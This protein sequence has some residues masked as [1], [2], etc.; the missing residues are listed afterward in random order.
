MNILDAIL[1]GLEK[2]EEGEHWAKRNNSQE[3]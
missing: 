3:I 1:G 2:L